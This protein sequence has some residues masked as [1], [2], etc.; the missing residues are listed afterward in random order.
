MACEE[1]CTPGWMT[2]GAVHHLQPPTQAGGEQPLGLEL[3]AVDAL[4]DRELHEDEGTGAAGEFRCHAGAQVDRCAATVGGVTRA[5]VLVALGLDVQLELRGETA[6]VQPADAAAECDAR[7]RQKIGAGGEGLVQH[8]LDEA[9]DVFR[10][11]R[12]PRG[13]GQQVGSPG[14]ELETAIETFAG[15]RARGE[16]LVEAAGGQFQAELYAEALFS[17]ETLIAGQQ[18]EIAQAAADIVLFKMVLV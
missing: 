10:R 14:A 11:A 13:A 2:S 9:A 17:G 4:V 15:L 3:Q 12:E 8:G 7:R 6:G 5:A 16:V 18:P 1:C